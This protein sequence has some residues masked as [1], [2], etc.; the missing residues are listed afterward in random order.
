MSN[1]LMKKINTFSNYKVDE[2]HTNIINKKSLHNV[3]ID[4]FLEISHLLDSSHFNYAIDKNLNFVSLC[5]R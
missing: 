1:I 5:K 2:K 4:E 3:D